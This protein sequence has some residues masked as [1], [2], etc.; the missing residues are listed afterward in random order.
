MQRQRLLIQVAITALLVTLSPL[1]TAAAPQQA[2]A[3]EECPPIGDEAVTDAR[4]ESQLSTTFALNTVLH[5]Q[6]IE[7]D[8]KRRVVYLFG[9][10][11]ND[12]KRELAALIAAN[13]DGVKDVQML[14]EV[15]PDAATRK[16]AERI[17]PEPSAPGTL[18]RSRPE[19]GRYMRAVADATTTALVKTRLMRSEHAHGIG[20]NVITKDSVVTL[21]GDVGTEAVRALTIELARSTRGVADV[22]SH[23]TVN[24]QPVGGM[25]TAAPAQ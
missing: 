8:V 15:D 20:I 17:P 4:L 3:A 13:T 21:N 2:K 6:P 14:L 22:V 10:V 24:G 1:I 23:L 7:V 25:D 9:A 18:E 19:M 16:K 12:I 5:D 11:D